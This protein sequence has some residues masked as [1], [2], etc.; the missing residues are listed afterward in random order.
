M[1]E[2]EKGE[3]EKFEFD[4]A[5]HMSLDRARVLALQHA[6][7]NLD[8]YGQ[9]SGGEP[10][11]AVLA[12]QETDDYYEIKL[13]FRPAR[14]ELSRR[15]GCRASHHRQRGLHRIPADSQRAP[16]FPPIRHWPLAEWNPLGSRGRDDRR[17]LRIGGVFTFQGSQSNCHGHHTE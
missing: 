4:S 12:A 7:D 5:G 13:S 1:A 16:P 10:V 9:H 2:E 15:C 17:T 3:V 14:P 11:W 6:R 8:F